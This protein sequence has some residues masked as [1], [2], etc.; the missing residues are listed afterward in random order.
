M[1]LHGD[2]QYWPMKSVLRRA[3]TV[4]YLF[5]SADE[6]HNG[7]LTTDEFTSWLKREGGST[8]DPGVIDLLHVF[9]S[10]DADEDGAVTELEFMCFL[11]QHAQDVQSLVTW[12][13]SKW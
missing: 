3:M 6:D 4:S 1:G 13:D 11:L 2:N 7:S 8:I 9:Q 5:A 12:I 10:I